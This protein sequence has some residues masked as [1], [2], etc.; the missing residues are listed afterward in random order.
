MSTSDLKRRVLT[1]VSIKIVIVVLAAIF[2][3]GRGLRPASAPMRLN[4]GS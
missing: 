1:V 2:M 4:A 3:F